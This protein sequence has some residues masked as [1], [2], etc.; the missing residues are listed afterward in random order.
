MKNQS[1]LGPYLVW[2]F[3][4]ISIIGVLIFRCVKTFVSNDWIIPYNLLIVCGIPLF[5]YYLWGNFVTVIDEYCETHSKSKF[6][7]IKNLIFI[8]DSLSYH[9]FYTV[10]WLICAEFCMCAVEFSR[11]Y[12]KY[13]ETVSLNI[14]LGVIFLAFSGLECRKVMLLELS[15]KESDLEDIKDD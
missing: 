5:L 15:E 10:Y 8:K 4:E 14:A 13:G 6:N 11:V 12:G 2:L 3:C 9:L 7:K 1:K